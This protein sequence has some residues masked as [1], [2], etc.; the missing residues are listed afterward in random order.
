LVSAV[1]HEVVGKAGQ[2][3]LEQRSC[4]IERIIQAGERKAMFMKRLVNINVPVPEE[5]LL[6]LRSENNEFAS[7][8]KSLIL[9]S[10]E[11]Y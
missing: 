10:V 1:G 9:A 8:T 11:M 5:V 6:S 4:Y 2:T 7:Q 3:F